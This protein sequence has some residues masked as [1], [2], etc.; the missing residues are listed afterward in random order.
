[1]LKPAIF[2]Y[3]GTFM[4]VN[5]KNKIIIYRVW[6]AVEIKPQFEIVSSLYNQQTTE[7]IKMTCSHILTWFHSV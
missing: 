6:I 4:I 5:T 3:N 2:S 7:G 1:M